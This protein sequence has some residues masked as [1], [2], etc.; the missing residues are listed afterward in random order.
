M[1]EPRFCHS[2]FCSLAWFCL[3][4]GLLFFIPRSVEADNWPQWRG[5]GLN[6]V[7]PESDVIESLSEDNRLWRV[8]LP[9]PGRIESDCLG[10]SNLCDVD[11]GTES[12]ADMYL[13]SVGID[14]EIQWRQ[15]M[16]G[17]NRNSRD[18]ANS[19]SPSPC[20][21]GEHVW[22]MMGNGILQCFTMTG[23]PVWKK[24][25][26]QAY[27]KFNIQFGMTTTPVLDDGRI[28]LALM[29]GNMRNRQR[30]FDRT[31]DC[32]GWRNRRGN[33]VSEATD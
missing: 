13:I 7:S 15:K 21:D 3:F 25:L 9:G 11:G 22:A 27:G 18:N 10:R 32:V 30:N 29:H 26:Q 6:S 28:Y 17:A 31:C 23:H 5:P 33:L 20:T 1:N 4:A 16:D 14:G 2:G 24:D 8:E 12:G 19:A